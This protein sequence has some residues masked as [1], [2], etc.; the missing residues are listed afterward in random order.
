M[1][2][3]RTADGRWHVPGHQPK[4][5]VRLEVPTDSAGLCDFLN[6]PAACEPEPSTTPITDRFESRAGRLIDKESISYTHQAVE[7]DEAWEGLS[8]AQKLHYA[9]LAMEDARN[10]L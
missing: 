1:K 8:L 7:L 9:S 2:L 3:Y 5:A 4:N 10:A 6:R